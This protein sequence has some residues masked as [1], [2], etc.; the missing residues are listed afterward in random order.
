M[1]CIVKIYFQNFCSCQCCEQFS[2]HLH[3][4]QIQRLSKNNKTVFWSRLQTRME[5]YIKAKLR[6][7]LLNKCLIFEF[8]IFSNSDWF[9][10]IKFTFSYFKYLFLSL[11]P[12]LC[13]SIT[14]SFFCQNCPIDFKLS[15]MIPVLGILL[16]FY[17]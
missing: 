15:M 17:A 4:S 9:I 12:V 3:F 14:D 10:I 7:T 13:P 2:S 11:G 1:I 5:T 6:F 8:Y 16:R